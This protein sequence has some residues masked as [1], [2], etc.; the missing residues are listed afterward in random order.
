MAKIK[1][2]QKLDGQKSIFSKYKTTFNNL[3]VFSGPLQMVWRRKGPIQW[4]YLTSY[5]I[6][7]DGDS[8]ISTL[9][10][11]IIFLPSLLRFGYKFT[12][13]ATLARH[14]SDTRWIQGTHVQKDLGCPLPFFLGLATRANGA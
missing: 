14:G 8:S 3:S 10:A 7:T 2:S 13:F 4:G 11:P 9:T 5:T 12:T 1:L 6:I